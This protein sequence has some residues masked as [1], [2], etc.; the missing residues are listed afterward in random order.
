MILAGG[1]IPLH[2]PLPGYEH[3][4]IWVSKDPVLRLLKRHPT[5]FPQSSSGKETRPVDVQSP[6]QE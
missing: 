5:V 1:F 2:I 4:P 3:L 6:K